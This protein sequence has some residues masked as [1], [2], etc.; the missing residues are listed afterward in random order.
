MNEVLRATGV[1][2]VLFCISNWPQEAVACPRCQL[3]ISVR[4]AVLADS[5][6]LH[7]TY[8]LAPFA[9]MLVITL[10]YVF[11]GQTAGSHN[12]VRRSQ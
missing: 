12:E 7:L 8:V 2:W 10:S 6:G 11:W 3:G 5:F 9:V 1:F 4:E